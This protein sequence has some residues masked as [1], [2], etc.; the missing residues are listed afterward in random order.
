MQKNR[1]FIPNEDLEKEEYG[2]YKMYK[3]KFY[4]LYNTTKL[5]I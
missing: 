3:K 4:I 1:G 2:G 5:L